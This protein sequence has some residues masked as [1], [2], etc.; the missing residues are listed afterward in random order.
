MTRDALLMDAAKSRRWR[1]RLAAVLLLPALLFSLAACSSDNDGLTQQF[2]EGGDKGFISG[3]GRVVEIPIEQRGEPVVFTGVSETGEELSSE[4]Y[5]GEVL[6]VNFWY[7]GCAPCRAEAAD[8]EAVHEQF[9]EA[10]ASFMGVNIY[11][12]PDTA[13]SFAKQYGVTYPSAM[14]AGD[15]PLKMAFA[16]VAP[17]QATPTTLVIDATGRVA[18]RIVGPIEG[19]STLS[20]LVRDT[21]AEG[22]TGA[23]REGAA[24]EG[25]AETDS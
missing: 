9:A 14:A 23:A 7:A 5:L 17:L 18:A 2:R 16:A 15:G 19:T 13:L 24:N 11:D 22:A 12:Q 4:D 3:D 10:G 21:I 25:P 20:T 8:L 1:A 6:V